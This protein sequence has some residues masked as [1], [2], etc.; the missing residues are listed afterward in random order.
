MLT[1]ECFKI[2][3]SNFPTE[4]SFTC[5]IE[6]NVETIKNSFLTS[7]GL[8]SGLRLGLIVPVNVLP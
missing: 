4:L 7:S 1:F 6:I 3:L 8:R 5:L 2:T